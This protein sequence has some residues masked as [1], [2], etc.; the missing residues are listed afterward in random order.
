MAAL[1]VVVE[2]QDLA[3]S[4]DIEGATA[5][6]QGTLQI[7]PSLDIDNPE[8]EARRLAAEAAIQHGEDLAYEGDIAG[9][10][11][12]YTNA[13]DIDPILEVSS[14][15]WNTLC[16]FGSLSGYAAEVL[17]VCEQGVKLAGRDRKAGNS[18][19]RGIARAITGDYAGAIEDF[20]MFIAW[21]KENGQ[22]EEY[23]AKR[24]AWVTALEAGQNPFDT[25][26]LEVLWDE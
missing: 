4:G 17:K 1:D 7:D 24:K 13:L 2:G 25:E 6:L 12:A 26:T 10:L 21:S 18:D 5:K 15:S 14:N 23:G 16:W 9:A 20:N 8:T 3:E 11:T 22:Y 19:S